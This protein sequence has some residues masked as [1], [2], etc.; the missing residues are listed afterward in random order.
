MKLLK[1]VSVFM[2]SASLLTA[3]VTAEAAP[4]DR[5]GKVKQLVA[6]IYTD[7]AVMVVLD[8][9]SS[10]L[11]P[12]T[13]SQWGVINLADQNRDGMLSLL[14]AAYL[15]RVNVTLSVEY[16]GSYCRIKYVSLNNPT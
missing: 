16:D 11:C 2:L 1:L 9:Y 4:V 12:G 7:Q 8:T 10:N 3:S 6:K 5:T 13:S 14:T 15:S